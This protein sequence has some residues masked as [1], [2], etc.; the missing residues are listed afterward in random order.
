M[1]RSHIKLD[2]PDF[3]FWLEKERKGT[4]EWEIAVPAARCYLRQNPFLLLC[5]DYNAL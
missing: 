5:Y 4:P 1:E 3:D 2:F